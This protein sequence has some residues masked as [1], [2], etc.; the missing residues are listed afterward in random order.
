MSWEIDK[1]NL[2]RN[3]DYLRG[4]RDKFKRNYNRK[5]REMRK[6]R[7]VFTAGFG[8]HYMGGYAVISA[9]SEEE[10]REMLKVEM[11]KHGL[12]NKVDSIELKELNITK[13]KAIVLF[14]GDY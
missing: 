10:A 8:G 3:V 2:E 1:R 4:E 11:E 7:K 12:A 9:T 13:S 14:D 5:L 6:I